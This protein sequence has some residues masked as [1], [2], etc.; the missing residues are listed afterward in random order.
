MLGPDAPRS[1]TPNGALM[2]G[3]A[4]SPR[5]DG[6]HI[7][8]GHGSRQLLDFHVTGS[9]VTTSPESWSVRGRKTDS[10]VTGSASESPSYSRKEEEDINTS[11]DIL[12]PAVDHMDLNLLPLSHYMSGMICTVQIQLSNAR[13]GPCSLCG[14][15]PN[16][17]HELG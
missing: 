10:N 9:C 15:P 5:A 16:R 4:I 8:T 12:R 6:R 17:Q 1:L 14:S 3:V 13:V 7:Q 2:A 11:P